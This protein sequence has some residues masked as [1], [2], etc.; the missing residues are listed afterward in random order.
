[1]IRRREF[2]A[3]GSAA[4]LTACGPRQVVI[5]PPVVSARVLRKVNVSP[6]REI[7]TVVGLRPFRPSGFVVRAEK[8]GDKLLVHNYGHGG[9][10]MTLSWGTSHLAV[11]EVMKG[12]DNRAAVLGC[13]AVGLATAR[14]LQQ[15][16]I[17]VTVYTKA[18]PPDTT[19]NIAGAQWFPFTVF[20]DANATPQFMDQFVRACRFSYRWFQNLVGSNYGVRWIPNY[21]WITLATSRDSPDE[22]ASFAT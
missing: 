3:A 12:G 22:R 13:G 2:L 4:A 1:L 16:G 21:S 20:D 8:A 7:R 15:R 11:E 19:S 9:G 10:G 17:A 5:S 6:E 14:L 18:L